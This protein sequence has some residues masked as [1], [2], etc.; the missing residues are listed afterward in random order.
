MLEQ[1]PI[2][3]RIDDYKIERILRGVQRTNNP[4]KENEGKRNL[5]WKELV[6]FSACHCV[7]HVLTSTAGKSLAETLEKANNRWWTNRHYKFHSN[8]HFLQV[9]HTVNAHLM[10]F[11]KDH[12]ASKPIILFEPST[13]SIE[14]LEMELS[15]N[16][17]VV[18]ILGDS[19][20]E[21]Y[22]V[23]KFIVD[24]SSESLALYQHMT[25]VFGMGAFK[26]LPDRIEA[27]SL[28]SGKST[29]GHRT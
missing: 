4:A 26:R 22:I 6:H 23:Q 14:E 28:L 13:V 27:L 18:S 5:H 15:Q 1:M 17:H 10:S 8:E 7:N 9:R 11:L 21:G 3:I 20:Q 2:L 29:F 25:T 12:V 19:I 24:E 16:L